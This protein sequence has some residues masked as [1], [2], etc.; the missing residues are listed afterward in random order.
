MVKA[1]CSAVGEA[2]GEGERV[3]EETL[4]IVRAMAVVMKEGFWSRGRLFSLPCP[5]R[6]S[7]FRPVSE[8]LGYLVVVRGIG[9]T[10]VHGQKGARGKN[11][12][13]R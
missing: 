7:E 4:R 6:F 10:M 3:E 5:T 12:P 2:E 1:W 8:H 11:S 9:Q 13:K